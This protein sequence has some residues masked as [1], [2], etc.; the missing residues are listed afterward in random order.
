[1]TLTLYTTQVIVLD[2]SFLEDTPIQ[3]YFVMVYVAVTFA[4][5]WRLLGLRRGPLESAVAWASGQARHL[6]ESRQGKSRKGQTQ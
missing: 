3:L 1:M 4:W 2:T 6:V 5:L